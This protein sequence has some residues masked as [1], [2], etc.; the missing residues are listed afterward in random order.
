MK[1]KDGDIRVDILCSICDEPIRE[2]YRW[3]TWF[4]EEHTIVDC[5]KH[6]SSRISVL[7][8]KDD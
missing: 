5:V 2:T 3:K 7:E 4:R 1:F 6:L 8:K